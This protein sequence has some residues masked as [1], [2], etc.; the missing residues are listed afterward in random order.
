MKPFTVT[1]RTWTARLRL[2]QLATWRWYRPW[3]PW[4][5]HA[6]FPGT[7]WYVMTGS[8]QMITAWIEDWADQEYREYHEKAGGIA[9]ARQRAL[10]HDVVI[11]MPWTAR[12]DSASP[13]RCPLC[14]TVTAGMERPSPWKAYRCCQCGQEFARMPRL[15]RFLPHA[16]LMCSGHGPKTLCSRRREEREADD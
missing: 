15:A 2:H 9:G 1:R 12:W 3:W 6:A 5:L 13:H 7:Q 14:R 11:A 10:F 8:R 4:E 16:G